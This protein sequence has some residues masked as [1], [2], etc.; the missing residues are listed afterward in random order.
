LRLPAHR[1]LLFLAPGTD[2][3]LLER[4]IDACHEVGFARVDRG[5]ISII[6][7]GRCLRF[8]EQGRFHF[9]RA[10]IDGPA[11]H[12]PAQAEKS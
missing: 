3:K 10:P 6:D 9:D 5:P 12:P 11:V 8:P 4:E 2:P 1:R 7:S